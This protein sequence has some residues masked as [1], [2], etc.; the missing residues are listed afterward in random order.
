MQTSVVNHAL[1]CIFF[2]K[3][4]K[5]RIYVKTRYEAQVSFPYAGRAEPGTGPSS[6]W[7][8]PFL[9]LRS[10]QALLEGVRP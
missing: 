10:T 9:Q 1:K 3:S 2:F 8:P 4:H 6:K 5:L 7:P